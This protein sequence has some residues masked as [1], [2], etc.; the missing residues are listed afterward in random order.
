MKSKERLKLEQAWFRQSVWQFF[1]EQLNQSSFLPSAHFFLH[2]NRFHLSTLLMLSRI[3][4]GTFSQSIRQR[5]YKAIG[6]HAWD[7][8]L[9]PWQDWAH[10]T[11]KWSRHTYM[12]IL[13]NECVMFWH[14]I[15]VS[16][17]LTK[18]AKYDTG[19]LKG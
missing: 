17:S 7:F 1:L 8:K 2:N 13:V 19:I 6:S 16:N 10:F 18:A 14:R 15:W 11:N 4:F 12:N 9:P 3:Q 5:A